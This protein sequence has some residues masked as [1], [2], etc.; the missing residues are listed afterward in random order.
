MN[1][2]ERAVLTVTSHEDLI[3][4]IAG[5]ESFRVQDRIYS[6]DLLTRQ[7]VVNTA[8]LA[9]EVG[10]CPAFLMHY[11]RQAAGARRYLA[12]VTSAYRSWRDR[13]FLEVKSSPVGETAKGDAKYPTDTQA[14]KIYRSAP[15]YGEW[16]AR[17]NDAQESAENAEVI[18]EAFKM[19]LEA[20]KI[21][22]RLLHDEAG[23]SYVVVEEP[24]RSIPRDPKTE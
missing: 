7:L 3:D 10:L 24:R 6:A 4:R 11:G 20:I 21:Q 15:E 8:D 18:Y 9:E 1:P 12:Q 2:N 17:I 14:E 22:Q 23:G 13:I 5:F 16:Q 19:K